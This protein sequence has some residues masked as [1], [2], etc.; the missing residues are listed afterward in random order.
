MKDIILM[1]E[2]NPDD[3]QLVARQLE[4][5]ALKHELRVVPDGR[6]AIDY[7][8]RATQHAGGNSLHLPCLLIIDLKVP[9][10]DGFALIEWVRKNPQTRQIPIIV[11][12]GSASPEDLQRA[13]ALGANAYF[14]KL[15]GTGHYNLLFAAIQEF[16]D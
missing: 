2:D 11:Y 3:A 6:E 5:S 4:H 16:C 10:V 15:T 13:Y 8:S 14:A 7:L 1:V 9:G 12:S